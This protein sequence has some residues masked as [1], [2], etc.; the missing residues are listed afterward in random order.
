LSPI[1]D[2]TFQY[3]NVLSTPVSVI[4][5]ADKNGMHSR[6]GIQ[7]KDNLV[8]VLLRQHIMA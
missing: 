3:L 6:G 4:G 7:E 2:H 5:E 1:V 8:G